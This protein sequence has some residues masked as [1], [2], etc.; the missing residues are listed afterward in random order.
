MYR[1][2]QL[3]SISRDSEV[4]Q[5]KMEFCIIELGS[6]AKCDKSSHSD[7]KKETRA[8]LDLALR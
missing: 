1:S 8:L 7:R 6:L 2:G 4:F 5:D 3:L